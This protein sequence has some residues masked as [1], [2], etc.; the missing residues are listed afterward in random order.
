MS[1]TERSEFLCYP[2]NFL[3]RITGGLP[4]D[5][6]A[7]SCLWPY[8]KTRQNNGSVIA[9]IVSADGAAMLHE[10]K[11]IR[12]S[13]RSFIMEEFLVDMRQMARCSE[14]KIESNAEVLVTPAD[15]KK[16]LRWLI[17]NPRNQG[18]VYDVFHKFHRDSFWIANAID[19]WFEREKMMLE[20][21]VRIQKQNGK[22]AKFFAT[23]HG[24]F[25]SVA[26]AAKAQLVKSY[27]LHM[28]RNA[29]WCIATT[30]RK[31]ETTKTVYTKIKLPECKDHYYMVTMLSR[32][33]SRERCIASGNVEL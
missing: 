23:D 11:H 20:G 28:L 30:Y 7:A 21:E 3:D 14:M 2:R 9:D 31:T 15:F 29:G 26:R 18:K 13:L 6:E 25:T 24:G 19:K 8:R 27:I 17:N 5:E 4:K 10:M 12:E 32:E 22:C 1:Q 33:S 16:I